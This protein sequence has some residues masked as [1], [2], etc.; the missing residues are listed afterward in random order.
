MK[1][2]EFLSVMREFVDRG[3]GI[4]NSSVPDG[5]ETDI[6]TGPVQKPKKDNSSFKKGVSTTTDKARKNTSQGDRW[7]WAFGGY[8][9]TPYSMGNKAV[10]QWSTQQG[11]FEDYD[12]DIKGAMKEVMEQ[13]LK[14]KNDTELNSNPIPDELKSDKKFMDIISAI[15]TMGASKK[16]LIKTLLDNA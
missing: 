1:K 15:K 7:Q 10:G 9:G 16:E 4:A 12:T 11:D 3:G 8:G 2:N 5:N 14:S 13:L 6:Q